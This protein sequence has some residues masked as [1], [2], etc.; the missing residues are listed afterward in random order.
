M[1]NGGRG[2]EGNVLNGVGRGMVQV[3]SLSAHSP[4]FGED[5]GR[6]DYQVAEGSSISITG[7]GIDRLD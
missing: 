7:R 1:G 3:A 6:G 4:K 2:G 5:R